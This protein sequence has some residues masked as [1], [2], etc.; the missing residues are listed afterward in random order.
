MRRPQTLVIAL[1][2]VLGFSGGS[3]PTVQGQNPSIV[4]AAPLEGRSGDTIYLSGAGFAPHE[5]LYIMMACPDWYDRSASQYGNIKL[6]QNGP[7][8][9][10][11]GRFQWFPFQA[12]ILHHFKLL[13]CQIH[14]SDGANA[15]GPDFPATYVVYAPDQQ[16]PTTSKWRKVWVKIHPSPRRVHSGLY[17]T[18]KISSWNAA[19][20]D[21]SI[22]Y[23]GAA[24]ETHT[25]QLDLHGEATV[26]FRAAIQ[27]GTSA[28]VRVDVR[29]HVKGRSGRGSANFTVV[30]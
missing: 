30:R 7:M 2:L 9:D 29:A 1:I 26:R 27:N 10:A 20:A 14:T 11:H 22:T 21:V 19:A 6:L 16:L 13:G 12:L 3:P 24:P 4:V 8:T 15:Y 23:P 28:Q 18:V 5:H 25:V 17:E